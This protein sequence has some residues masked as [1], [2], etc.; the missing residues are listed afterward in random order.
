MKDENRYGW[1]CPGC[2]QL[3]CDAAYERTLLCPPCLAGQFGGRE[4]HEPVRLFEP[5][6]EQ[7]AGQ[8]SL[9]A[10]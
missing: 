3:T 7:L 1:T 5:A 10:S 2:G 6:P 4:R 9:D 8:L